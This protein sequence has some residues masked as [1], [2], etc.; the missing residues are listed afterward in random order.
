MW[1]LPRFDPHDCDGH[2]ILGGADGITP[3]ECRDLLVWAEWFEHF[4]RRVALTEITKDVHVSTV[5]L[6]LDHSYERFLARAEWEPL[7]PPI[8]F[9]TMVFWRNAKYPGTY[10][11]EMGDAT[12]EIEEMEFHGEDQARAATYAEALQQHHEM[13][14][15]AREEVATGRTTSRREDR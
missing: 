6:G 12:R 4:D 10:T 8:L 15:R 9:E 11:L 13:V 5:F 14:E 1:R 2:Y 7:P 3:V